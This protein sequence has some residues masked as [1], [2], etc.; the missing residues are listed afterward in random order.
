MNSKYLAVAEELEKLLPNLIS[1]GISKLP[2]ESELCKKYNCSRQTIRNALEILQQKNLIL[3]QKGSGSY[4]SPSSA[5]AKIALIL[6]HCSEYIFPAIQKA[7]GQFFS[8]CSLE[9]TSYDSE[10]SILKEREILEDLLRNPPAGIIIYPVMAQVYLNTDIIK[11]LSDLK[12]PTVFL[13]YIPN[14]P[15]SVLTAAADA[16][17]GSYDTAIKLS[18]GGQRKLKA[19]LAISDPAGS[20]KFEGLMRAS[21][22]NSLGFDESDIILLSDNEIKDIQ[23]SNYRRLTAIIGENITRGSSIFCGNDEIAYHI[24][25]LLSKMH[26]RIP[27]DINISGFDNSYYCTVS[28]PSI[29][30]VGTDRDAVITAACRILLRLITG[31]EAESVSIPMN[32]Y[33][34]RSTSH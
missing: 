23:N 16:Q 5:K 6:P 30:S 21:I 4:I 26:F 9:L 3:K 17:G 20:A 14:L 2:S 8:R 28:A 18:Q 19:F 25:K 34:R 24:V 1:L 12:I 27:E 33:E 31:K 10:G 29:T 7:A 22:D 13:A 32:I 15:K 11:R